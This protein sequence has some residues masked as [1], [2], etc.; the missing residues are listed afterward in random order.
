MRKDSINKRVFRNGNY[1]DSMAWMSISYEDYKEMCE[2]MGMEPKEEGSAE[3][4]GEVIKYMNDDFD[5]FKCNLKYSSEWNVPCM[6][7]GTMGLWNGRP[8]IVPVLCNNL[9]EASEK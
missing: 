8:T 4:I 7:T 2:E 5:D 9:V 1:Y 3:Q 6:I